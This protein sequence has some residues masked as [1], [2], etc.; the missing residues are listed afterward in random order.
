MLYYDNTYSIYSSI[1]AL[2]SLQTFSHQKIRELLMNGLHFLCNLK[3][4]LF[5]RIRCVIV[6]WCTETQK[7]GNLIKHNSV[8]C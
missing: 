7:F 1:D 5:I 4:P 3:Y 6:R 8:S 2:K